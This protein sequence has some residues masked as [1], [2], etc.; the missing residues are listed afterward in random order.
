MPLAPWES[1][2]DQ[3][4]LLPSQVFF[5][6][7]FPAW[8]TLSRSDLWALQNYTKLGKSSWH[9]YAV[10]R[11]YCNSCSCARIEPMNFELWVQPLN[12]CGVDLSTRINTKQLHYLIWITINNTL[13]YLNESSILS[14]LADLCILQVWVRNQ[15][16][17]RLSSDSAIGR[18]LKETID[19]EEPLLERVPVIDVKTGIGESI[20]RRLSMSSKNSM[21]SFAV[22]F[23]SWWLKKSRVSTFIA[24][25]L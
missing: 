16:R 24:V 25:K 8:S 10:P 5:S 18:R 11:S 7:I 3:S 21:Q 14:F 19:I 2:H 22:L 12:I 17:I 6:S 23:P 1:R 9:E 13:Y 4:V 20:A 15:Y